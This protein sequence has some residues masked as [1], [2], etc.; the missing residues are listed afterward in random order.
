MGFLG[1]LIPPQYRLA[2]EIAVLVIYTGATVHITSTFI[3]NKWEA[4]QAEQV[5]DA[6]ILKTKLETEASNLKDALFNTTQQHEADKNEAVQKINNLEHDLRQ[7]AATNGLRD[8]GRLQR[9]SCQTPTPAVPGVPSQ[10]ADGGS[11]EEHPELSGRLSEFLLRKFS[12]AS[13][14][15]VGREQCRDDFTSMIDQVN[16]YAD[17]V[18]G[19]KK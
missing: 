18:E 19:L 16:A 17:R 8:P 14:V 2:I 6:A 4:K 11:E 15:V 7:R 12:D 1:L 3:N 9:R 13:Q 5:R 10:P